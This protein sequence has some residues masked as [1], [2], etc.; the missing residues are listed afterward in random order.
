M[1]SI[2]L[3][4]WEGE[5]VEIGHR[6]PRQSEVLDMLAAE[7]LAAA[8]RDERS[9]LIDAPTYHG[10]ALDYLSRLVTTIRGVELK[11][12]DARA[13][14]DENC[15]AGPIREATAAIYSARLV[16]PSLGNGSPSGGDG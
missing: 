6:W 7:T 9:A 5:A 1:P 13:W 16:A 10:I 15:A 4:T 12:T 14:L 2:K 11:S 8:S 3:T